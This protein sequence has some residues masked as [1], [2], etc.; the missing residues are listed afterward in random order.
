MIDFS[1]TIQTNTNQKISETSTYIGRLTRL[2][3][4][5]DKQQKLEVRQLTSDFKNIVEKY[6]KSQQVIAAKMKQVLLVNPLIHD[7]DDDEGSRENKARSALIQ[8][9]EQRDLEFEQ[10][11]LLERERQMRQIEDDVIDVHQ[12]FQNLSSLVEV[13]GNAVGESFD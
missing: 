12:I 4:G 8:E 10:E 1:H 6:H 11:M 3:Q 7:D 2:T 5:G 9:Q 13:Q